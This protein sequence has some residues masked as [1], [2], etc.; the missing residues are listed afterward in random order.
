MYKKL[1][2]VGFLV[3]VCL[4]VVG[5]DTRIVQAVFIEDDGGSPDPGGGNNPPVDDNLNPGQNQAEAPP[6]GGGPTYQP[7][8]PPPADTPVDTP[9]VPEPDYVPPPPPPPGTTDPGAGDPL[10]FTP[11][12]NPQPGDPGPDPDP[13]QPPNPTPV[14]MGQLTSYCRG[15]NDPVI[16]MNWS[17]G[18]NARYFKVFRSDMGT[19]VANTLPDVKQYEE[20][21][22]NNC[23]DNGCTTP[24]VTRFNH[25]LAN[26]TVYSYAIEA[27]PNNGATTPSWTASF[28][29]VRTANCAPP[30][31]DPSPV[32]FDPV[33][34]YCAAEN[35]PVIRLSWSNDH[36]ARYFKLFQYDGQTGLQHGAAYIS[37]DYSLLD[38]YSVSGCDPSGCTQPGYATRFDH[39]VQNSGY[40]YYGIESM[41]LAR[42]TGGSGWSDWIGPIQAPYCGPS[43]CQSEANNCGER[44]QGTVSPSYACNATTPVCAAP[45]IP[46]NGSGATDSVCDTAG[47]ISWT[48]KSGLFNGSYGYSIDISRDV[49]FGVKYSKWIAAPQGSNSGSTTLPTDVNWQ[50]FN[51]TGDPGSDRWFVRVWNGSFS[52]TVSFNIQTCSPTL[53]FEIRFGGTQTSGNVSFHDGDLANLNWTAHNATGC[54]AGFNWSGKKDTS[55]NESLGSLYATSSPYRFDLTCTRLSNSITKSINV[56]VYKSAYFKTSGGNVHSNENITTLGQ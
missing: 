26:D 40:Y 4:F 3:L 15:V 1:V 50:G 42:A 36:T 44:G 23:P 39:L 29:S 7:P 19:Q 20:Y 35:V 41:A 32:S 8:P 49:N 22:L 34:T 9:I 48:G 47:M 2:L 54:T 5:A 25:D 16:N 38:D 24:T 52:N 21:G 13:N 27:M 18:D 28:T 33:T 11:P 31:P 56:Q 51:G 30:P 14:Y 53:D 17:G 10:P 43:P 6:T 46:T 12:D 55:G 37:P 45:Y